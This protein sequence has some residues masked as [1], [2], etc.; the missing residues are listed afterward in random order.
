MRRP[1]QRGTHPDRMGVV[2]ARRLRRVRPPGLDRPT[3]SVS[4]LDQPTPVARVIARG[5]KL[6]RRRQIARGVAGTALTMVLAGTALASTLYTHPPTSDPRPTKQLEP[7]NVELAGWSV[8]T[9]PGSTLTITLRDPHLFDFE[10][11]QLIDAD[12]LRATLAAAGVPVVLEFHDLTA[13]QGVTTIDCHGGSPDEAALTERVLVREAGGVLID[14]MPGAHTW[15]ITLRPNEMP[16]GAV[17]QLLLVPNRTT[18]YD[19]AGAVVGHGYAWSTA[20]VVFPSSPPPC[21]FTPET[22]TG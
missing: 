4:D 18:T 14:E 2:H 3:D 16:R 6:R 19:R 22:P 15:V 7:V 5:Q 9:N 20:A 21:T 1:G 12:R 17:L 11:P 8:R 13:A 10:N